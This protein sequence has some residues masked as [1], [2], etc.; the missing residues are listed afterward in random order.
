MVRLAAL[1]YIE[2][3]FSFGLLRGE[4]NGKPLVCGTIGL[5][6]DRA[7]GDGLEE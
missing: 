7:I 5:K 3:S 2:N 1:R 4:F 6:G